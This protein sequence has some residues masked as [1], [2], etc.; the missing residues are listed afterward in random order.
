MIWGLS[1]TAVSTDPAEPLGEDGNDLVLG[2]VARA[3]AGT[4]DQGPQLVVREGES[5]LG[6]HPSVASTERIDARGLRYLVL[7]DA[8][9]AVA[10]N[11]LLSAEYAPVVDP[12]HKGVTVNQIVAA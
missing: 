2:E 3:L 8:Q 6:G 1:T 5:L 11:A 9:T 7:N 12:Q 10:S 4:F